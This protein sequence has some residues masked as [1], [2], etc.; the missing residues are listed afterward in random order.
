MKPIS[1]CLTLLLCLSL[2]LSAQ[3]LQQALRPVKLDKQLPAANYSGLTRISRDDYAVVDDQSAHD[4]FCILSMPIDSISG[5]LHLQQVALRASHF[6]SLPNRDAEDICL[7]P[8]TQT[9]LVAGEADSRLIEYTRDGQLTGRSSAA[10]LPHPISNHGLEGLCYDPTSHTVWAMEENNGAG[11]ARLI[12]L[13]TELQPL[14]TLHYPLD[15]PKASKA[16]R[17]HAHGVS[18]VLHYADSRL[19]VLEREVYVPKRKIGAWTRCSLYIFDTATLHK[20]LLWHVRTRMSLTSRSFANYEA[21]CWGP[22]LA[23]GSRTL[24]LLTDSQNRYAGFLHDWLQI[25]LIR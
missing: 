20:T 9:L 2:P 17:N 18:A 11:V 6:S 21:L 1:L 22:T 14:R 7:L 5:Q 3:R 10:L 24:L 25:L 4:G 15:A 23:D 12:Q 13:D 19:L 16:G 8:H